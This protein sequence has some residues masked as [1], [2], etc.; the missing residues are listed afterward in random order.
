MEMFA[1]ILKWASWPA[2]IFL[3]VVWLPL[4]D[5]SGAPQDLRTEATL[6][7]AASVILFFGATLILSSAR[8]KSWWLALT[9]ALLLAAVIV[10]ASYF[11]TSK[12]WL[13]K[14]NSKTF[15]IG[16]KLLPEVEA[17]VRDEE[18][19]TQKKVE[20]EK[21]LTGTAELDIRAEYAWQK[22]GIERHRNILIALYFSI[23]PIYLSLL[24]SASQFLLCSLQPKIASP[25]RSSET[26]S[27]YERNF[28]V[29]IS[30]ARDD[31]E[32]P[33]PKHRWL[34]RLLQHLKPLVMQ[35][36]VRVWSDSDIKTGEEWHQS[37]QNEL[38]NARVAVLLVSPAYLASEYIR[39]N[40]LPKLLM[41]AKKTGVK[42]LPI[43]I[44]TCMFSAATFKY[45][46]PSGHTYEVPLSDFQSAN[47]P[48]RPLS[49]MKEH[50]QD[51]VLVSIALQI[52]ELSKDKA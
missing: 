44:R 31:N 37:I 47:L 21:I 2:S 33:D 25:K 19:H 29:F 48:E 1:K 22:D 5:S 28:T 17:S 8:Y 43:I 52:Q 46:D 10:S 27:G 24:S 11:W 4:P 3:G 20:C 38:Q 26:E 12:K 23:I 15:V 14:V 39:N 30:Y 18:Q 34:D 7:I 6:L 36:Q 16:S 9:G 49:K 51:E 41:N 13:C 32:D 35:D 45:T 40:E 42:V 50:E